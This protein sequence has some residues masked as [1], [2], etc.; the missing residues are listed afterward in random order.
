MRIETLAKWHE[1]GLFDSGEPELDEWLK[2][3]ASQ[4]ARR[5]TT[6]TRVLVNDDDPRVLGYYSQSAYRLD[7]E[8][9]A[10]VFG[11]EQRP[12]YPIPCVLIARLA[13][14]Q[15]VRGQ[16]VGELLLAHALRSCTRVSREI[17]IEMVIVH[18]ISERA[19]VFYERFGFV[20]FVD[21]PHSLMLPV[22]VLERD[23]SDDTNA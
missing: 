2:K 1:R 17:G 19:V 4:S 15:S 22:K 5:R 12:R 13:R 20:R 10:A 3:T 9:L 14:C 16:G 6:L 21:H 8:E 23:Y 7:A 18:A 11:A